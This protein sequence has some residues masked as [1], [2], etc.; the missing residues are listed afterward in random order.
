VLTGRIG[1][2]CSELGDVHLLHA[3]TPV[4]CG[5]AALR[6]G[7][8]LG[9][10]VVYEVRGLWEEAIAANR[11][12]RRLTPRYLLARRMERRVCLSADRVITIADGLRAEYMRYGLA[13]GKIRVVPNGVD[14]TIFSPRTPPSE[15]RRALGLPTGPL[16]LYLG[17]LRRYEGIHLLLDAFAEVKKRMPQAR[18]AIV[19]EGDERRPA[20][21]KAAEMNG[22][23]AI[24]PAVPHDR[25]P[26]YYAAA[27]IVVYPRIS[28]RATELVTPLKTLEAMA[29]GKA[30]VASDVGGLRELLTDGVTARL[31][32]ASSREALAEVSVAL[33]RDPEACRRLGEAAAAE[34][35]AR[36]DWGEIGKKYEQIYA[37]LVKA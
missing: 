30:I 14:T 6:A 8:R 9:L 7:R 20:E 12:W 22:A 25:V 26:G 28:T 27:D 34:A 24:L 10:P 32:P 37:G 17:A 2:V 4:L 31:F 33:L 3:H 13:P 36:W 11:K 23:A 19:G 15:E 5:L 16:V 35:R 1:E 29:M 21:A 18:L